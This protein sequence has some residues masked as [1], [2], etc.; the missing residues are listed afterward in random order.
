[1]LD[2]F[3]IGNF[4]LTSSTDIT[5]LCRSCTGNQSWYCGFL[6]SNNLCT[7]LLHSMVAFLRR[8]TSAIIYPCCFG[9]SICSPRSMSV[10][11][12]LPLEPCV[13]LL[14][15]VIPSTFTVPGLALLCANLDS[16]KNLHRPCSPRFLTCRCN[17]GAWSHDDWEFNRQVH[18]FCASLDS[19][20]GT[21]ARRSG[22]YLVEILATSVDADHHWQRKQTC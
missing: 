15:P 2:I 16:V 18:T 19:N 1:M 3:L 13:R 12:C 11:V 20:L 21:D 5:I 7:V 8:C 6:L 4:A 14:Q 10:A 17:R 22:E 9:L